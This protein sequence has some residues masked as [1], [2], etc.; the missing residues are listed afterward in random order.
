MEKPWTTGIFVERDLG[1]TAWTGCS[2]SSWTVSYNG[3]SW[4]SS[5]QQLWFGSRMCFIAIDT[6]SWYMY[7][8]GDVHPQGRNH[9]RHFGWHSPSQMA[10]LCQPSLATV[11]GDPYWDAHIWERITRLAEVKLPGG[12][13]CEYLPIH[14]CWLSPILIANDES[15]DWPRKMIMANKYWW[16]LMVMIDS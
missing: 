11:A 3:R 1:A 12:W 8:T 10:L 6:G 13:P 15:W 4:E 9:R 5:Y 2:S 14:H 7:V 16:I